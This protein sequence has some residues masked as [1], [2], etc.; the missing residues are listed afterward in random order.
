MAE[1]TPPIV[2]LAEWFQ[3]PPGQYVLAWERAQFDAAVADVFGYYAWQVG[4]ADWNLLRANRMPFKGCVGT[5]AP[6]PEHAE[7]WQARVVLAQ[8]EA[9]PF[10]SQSVDLL[11]LPHAFECTAEPHN[12]LREV[13]RVLVPEGRVVISGFNPWAR[14]RMPGMEPWLPQPPS[15]QVSLPRLK[16]WF[17][18][19]SLEVKQSHFGCYAPACRSEKWLRRWGFL[20][21]AG[22]RWWSLGGAVYLVSAVKRVPGMRIIGPAWKT[23]ASAPAPLPSWSTARPTKTGRAPEPA[24]FAN[25]INRTPASLMQDSK[26]IE[27]KVEMWTD[28]ACKGNPGPGGWGVLMRAGAHEKTLHGGE[29]QTTNNRMELLA[30]IEG[31][32]ALKRSCVVTIHTDSQYV[33]KGMTEWLANWKRRG[34]ITA[35]KKPVKNAELWQALDEQVGRHQVS[36]RW[37]KGHAGDPGNERADQLANQGVEVAR[38]P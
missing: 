14:A 25:R 23:P 4:L 9:L 6:A 24:A 7:A 16:D 19:L 20:E 36:W 31:L 10:E 2:E 21:S 8:P 11:V 33:M 30:V 35:D 13:E 27:Q 34:W 26:P 28:G 32:R 12:V 18:L 37:V 5:E 22:A 17:K 29:R 38:R 15:S 1:E 3:T